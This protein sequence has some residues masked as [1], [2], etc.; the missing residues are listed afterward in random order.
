MK[1]SYIFFF[2]LMLTRSLPL[3][4]NSNDRGDLLICVLSAPLPLNTCIS[5]SGDCRSLSGVPQFIQLVPYVFI[6]LFPTVLYYLSNFVASSSITTAGWVGPLRESTRSCNTH[7]HMLPA[8]H[9]YI[10]H[11]YAPALCPAPCS[12]IFLLSHHCF[13]LSHNCRKKEIKNE[14]Y[15]NAHMCLHIL[16][17]TEISSKGSK[18]NKVFFPQLN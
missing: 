7:T 13:L 18:W 3:R 12:V 6:Y 16:Y 1:H 9:E 4:G 15:L 14:V 17:Q 11:Y 5:S 10:F 2:L 8:T